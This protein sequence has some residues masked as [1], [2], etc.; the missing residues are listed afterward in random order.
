[1]SLQEQKERLVKLQQK[2]AAYGHAEGLIYFDGTTGAPKGT[3]ENRAQ[4]LG[5]LSEELYNLSTGQDTI[6]LL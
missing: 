5:I 6:D 2:M 3:A 1:M 4:T